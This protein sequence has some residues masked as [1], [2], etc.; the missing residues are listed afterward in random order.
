VSTTLED[1][2]IL[3]LRE[4]AAI[5]GH[6]YWQFLEDLYLISAQRW[7]KVYK[8]RQRPTPDMVEA[9]CR[10]RPDYAF[11]I[12]T[13]ITDAENGHIAPETAL[14]FPETPQAHRPHPVSHDLAVSYFSH[15]LVLLRRLYEVVDLDDDESRLAALER[16]SM[17]GKKGWMSSELANHA[18]AIAETKEYRDLYSMR[19]EREQCR[20]DWKG[21]S[22]DPMG[23]L[24]P[25]KDL[26]W[27]PTHIAE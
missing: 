5:H 14:T 4:G 7:R 21:A 18:S 13:G 27:Q 15:S 24:Q 22:N 12:A 11:W 23:G 9:L 17:P 19:I 8:R 1:R 10:S 6:G 3:T 20:A 26:F 16:I 25:P 2:L